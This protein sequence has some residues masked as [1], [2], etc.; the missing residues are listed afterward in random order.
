MSTTDTFAARL[1]KGTP[2]AENILKVRTAKFETG[3]VLQGVLDFVNRAVIEHLM[4]HLKRVLL[5]GASGKVDVSRR[6]FR[7]WR[8]RSRRRRRTNVVVH[9]KNVVVLKSHIYNMA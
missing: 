8:C 6:C 2:S 3:G 1:A 5:D 9:A 7:L 4:E